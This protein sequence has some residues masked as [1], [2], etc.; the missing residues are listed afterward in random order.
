MTGIYEI[1]DRHGR[2]L[3]FVTATSTRQA[4]QLAREDGHVTATAATWIRTA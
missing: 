2:H 1:T 4:V 3:C